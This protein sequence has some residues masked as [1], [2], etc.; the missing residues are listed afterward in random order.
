[1]ADA[2]GRRADFRADING[3]RAWAVIVV[4]L[5]HFGIPGF[6][7]GFVGVDVFFVI[8]GFLMTSIVVKGLER[9]NFSLLGFYLARARRIIPALAA[10]C[11]ALLILGW[12]ALIPMEYRTLGAH[13]VYS[14]AF[15]S[16]INFWLEAGYFDV[17][18]HE[19]WLLHTWSLAVEWQFYLLLPLGLTAL[20]KVRPGRKELT[21][22][23]SS[24]FAA[25]LIGSMWL[26]AINPSAAF[27][28]LPTRAWEM[29]A[30]GLVF[31][32]I[33]NTTLSPT[34]PRISAS[35]LEWSGI[36]LIVF[37]VAVFDTSSAWPGW[38]ALVPVIGAMLVIFAA[39][40]KS[41]LTATPIAQWLGTRSYSLY[42]WHW[43]I[44][45]ALAYLEL[46]G[47]PV[48]ITAGLLMTLLLGHI[49]Y[50]W[51]ERPSLNK[52]NTLKLRWGVVAALGLTLAVAV[53]AAGVRLGDGVAWRVAREVSFAD[54]EAMNLHPR[55]KEC[56]LSAVGGLSPGCIHGGSELRVVVLGDSHAH[57]LVSAVEASKE[58][59][60]Y[61][62]MELSYGGGC[63]I[64]IDVK[65]TV[66]PD[67]Q[68]SDFVNWSLKKVS[69]LD[70]KIPAVMVSR[71]SLYVFGDN[72]KDTTFQSPWVHFSR[73]YKS[74]EPEFIKEYAQHLTETACLIAKDRPVY[75]VRPIPEMG[76]DVP[77]TM[78]RKLMNEKNFEVSISLEEYR[79]RQDFV[80]AAQDA[81][82]NKCGVKILDPLPYLC[83][84][85]RCYGSKDGR[86]LYYD[87]DH[88]SQFGNKLL[89]PMFAEV[90]KNL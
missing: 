58:N 9:G 47:D 67:N 29:L 11:A 88:L 65:R 66:K 51:I 24:V 2:T 33:S 23:V 85:G 77:K 7:G 6:N 18:S 27:Y 60:S 30:G 74:A 76:V 54:L 56:F 19:K 14:L 80:W 53:P 62:V 28:L 43:P 37:A 5:Y 87:H 59:K 78:A 63:P 26:T 4:I 69:S 36:S 71:H 84:D 42:L 25:S 44:V 49:S 35:R 1:M 82:R 83:R 75:L 48:A 41:P 12:W 86:P 81:A 89:V 72:K 79:K 61:G 73:I 39:Q 68:C 20:W 22:A 21:V 13:T 50:H 90:F 16:N 15:V 57:S 55:Q 52:L 32:L 3:L 34:P 45:V 40:E 8:S 31:L 46:K 17:A 10:L 70:K 64:L 38:R